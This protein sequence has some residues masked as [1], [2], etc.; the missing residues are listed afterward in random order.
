M[1]TAVCL[2]RAS[3]LCV[4][5]NHLLLCLSDSD[6]ESRSAAEDLLFLRPTGAREKSRIFILIVA[7]E[8]CFSGGL[9]SACVCVSVCVLVA[10]V[11][12]RL[13]LRHDLLRTIVKIYL[14]IEF[15]SICLALRL[16]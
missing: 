5:A 15:H 4:S 14:R 6:S 9:L 8:I 1:A 2:D 3:E 7:S 11:K 12:P 13:V 16:A 10:R